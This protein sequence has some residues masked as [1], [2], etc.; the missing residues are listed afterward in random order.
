M[1]SRKRTP[2]TADE[3]MILGNFRM[4]QFAWEKRNQPLDCDLIRELHHCGVQEIDDAKYKPGQF[5]TSD[6]VVV[7]D[8]DGQIVHQPPAHKE[9]EQRLQQLCAWVNN[10]GDPSSLHLHP[11]LK[12]CILHFAIAFE[13]PFHD[14]NGRVARALF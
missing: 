12:A 7:V 11:L 14:G 4:M 8:Q 10:D 2:R 13:H 5:R 9:L 1:L 3:R 6:E